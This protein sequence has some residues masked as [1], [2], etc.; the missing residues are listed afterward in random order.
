VGGLG[1]S[2]IAHVYGLPEAAIAQ[3]IVRAKRRLR[4]VGATFQAAA[5]VRERVPA[6]LTVLYLMFTEAH[7]TSSGTP[8]TDTELADEAIRLT[9]LLLTAVP[10]DTEIAGLLALML[11]THARQPGRIST[12][13]ELIP[14]DEQDRTL[15]NSTLIDE[16]LTLLDRAVPGTAPGPYLLQACIAGLH[17]Q[18][19]STETTDWRE[20]RAL[21]R[22]LQKQSPANPS[23]AVNAAVAEAMVAGPEAGLEALEAI[24]PQ[25]PRVLSVAAHLYERL[26]DIDAAV[27][28]Y[29]AAIKHTVSIAERHYLIRRV[30]ALHQ[31][32][33]S[34]D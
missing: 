23:I 10:D 13:G 24:S 8:A 16:G 19:S 3:R 30:A 33:S 26:G 29:R 15:W 4:D 5:D 32:L 27:E 20:I 2:Q 18:A 12:S 22:L 11:L 31:P 17:A 25:P 14:L 9:R 28:H 6:V 34:P 1:T 7:H 21:Y